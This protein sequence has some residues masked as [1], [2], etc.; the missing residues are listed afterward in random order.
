VELW[1]LPDISLVGPRQPL[2]NLPGVL[3]ESSASF[4]K[5]VRDVGSDGT[6]IDV[7]P[8]LS[9]PISLGGYATLTPFAGG[10][11]TAY[12]RTVTGTH[13]STGVLVEDTNHDARLRR[14]FEAGA[15]LETKV[16][17]VFTTDGWWGTESLLHTIEPRVR[18]ERVTGKGQ[19]RLP[20]WTV[21]VDD[22]QDSSR[23]EYSLTNRIRARTAAVPDTD[24]LRWEMFRLTLGHSYDLRH[25]R[26]GDLFSTVIVQPKPTIRFRSDISYDPIENTIP[27]GTADVSV[28]FPLTSANLGIRYSEPSKI[29]FLQGGFNIAA[30]SRVT[31][32]SAINWDLWHGKFSESRVAAD[33]HWK[34]WALTVEFV[35]RVDRDNEIR[36]AVNLLGVGGPIGTS[37]G[38]GA[39]ES[40]G[41]K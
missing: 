16:S 35:N 17:R 1:R 24:P 30:W 14:L 7:H 25:D 38:L 27:S 2:F 34:C 6:R 18:Y 26:V 31:L 28:S 19:D 32:R 29:T 10:R 37:V 20:Q 11:L 22:I 5:F 36:F 40:G 15:D 33:L 3:F 39:L 9:R 4:V 41:Q 12:D 21:G 8:Q 13:V 23:V